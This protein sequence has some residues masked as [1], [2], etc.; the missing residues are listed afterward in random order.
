MFTGIIQEL[1]HISRL[2]ARPQGLELG[3][4]VPKSYLRTRLGESI[5]V[6]GAC[7]T[8]MNKTA[9][10]LLF[11]CQKETLDRTNIP[12]L[13]LGE[14]VNLELALKLSDRLGG[15]MI[16]GHVDGVVTLDKKENLGEGKRYWIHLSKFFPGLL[17]KGSVALDGISLSISRLTKK[18]L[19][20]D[21]IPHTFQHT[22]ISLWKKGE[23]IN[24]ESDLIGKYVHTFLKTHKS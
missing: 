19:A 9:K 7:L 16:Q 20:V 18:K 17:M 6:N 3:I 24:L 15:H 22:N 8:V 4:F 11:F 5:S 10:E 12:F 1:G 13:T 2:K 14:A 21:V 23:R